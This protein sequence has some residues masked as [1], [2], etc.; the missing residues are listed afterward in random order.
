MPTKDI[1]KINPDRVHDVHV[2]DKSRNLESFIVRDA[3]RQLRDALQRRQHYVIAL[4]G[5]SKQGKTSILR[6]IFESDFRALHVELGASATS[7]K[8]YRT[9]LNETRAT[10]K[11]T[12]RRR[13][14]FVWGIEK[15]IVG[16]REDEEERGA[17]IAD[18]DFT[19][20]NWVTRQLEKSTDVRII[21]IDNFHH[22]SPVEQ[23][24]LAKDFTCLGAK[25]FK[26]VIAGTW[27][28]TDYL[29]ALNTDLSEGYK[30]LS[31]D[32]WS[33]DELHAVVM[34]GAGVLGYEMP[35]ASAD[36]LAHVAR[37]SIAALQAITARFYLDQIAG[38]PVYHKVNDAQKANVA[39]TTIANDRAPQLAKNLLEVAQW[40]A[41]DSTGRSK[42][43][44][45]VEAL[46]EASPDELRKGF[47]EAALKAKVDACAKNW[48]K[49]MKS[50]PELMSPQEFGNKIK[51]GWMAHQIE[52]N[53]TPIVVFDRHKEKITVNDSMI[54]FVH[55]LNSHL[56]RAEFMKC[57]KRA[58]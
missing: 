46:L 42:V 56:L 30:S 38:A 31:I 29:S 3:E 35:K 1:A 11:E 33:N 43:S 41:M 32:P 12:V 2:I 48:A 50:K 54:V 57:V 39:A 47:N 53:N 26:I 10:V 49:E 5:A 9:L 37:G 17:E 16:R 36:A 45:V 23:R 34:K 14:K 21:V 58:L 28:D 52:K 8:I 20:I 24:I 19:E 15:L 51:N 18:G 27:K 13:G 40:G 4:H 44:F 6:S 22:V 55:S 25:N 7:E